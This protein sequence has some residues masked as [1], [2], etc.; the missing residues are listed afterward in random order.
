MTA[1]ESQERH[2]IRQRITRVDSWLH[3]PADSFG[4]CDTCHRNGALWLD[5]D[6]AEDG[7]EGHWEYCRACWTARLDRLRSRLATK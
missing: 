3:G 1:A 2:A 4:E 5:M 7:D 6:A